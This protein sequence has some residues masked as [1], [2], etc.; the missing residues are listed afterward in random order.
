MLKIWIL[1]LQGLRHSKHMNESSLDHLINVLQLFKD[2]EFIFTFPFP[3]S[4]QTT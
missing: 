4:V 3:F 1:G 2:M